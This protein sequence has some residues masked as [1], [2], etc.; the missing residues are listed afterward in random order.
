MI[1]GPYKQ[2]HKIIFEQGWNEHS[3]L[4]FALQFIYNTGNMHH[5]IEYLRACQEFEIENEMDA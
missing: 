5:F 3:V 4:F 2:L 1:Y